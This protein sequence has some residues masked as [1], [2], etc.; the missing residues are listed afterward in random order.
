MG[1]T[2]HQKKKTKL[3]LFRKGTY[4]PATVQEE[5]SYLLANGISHRRM[6]MALKWQKSLSAAV[7]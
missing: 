5:I 4:D 7:Q 6:M 2:L 3:M 1:Q